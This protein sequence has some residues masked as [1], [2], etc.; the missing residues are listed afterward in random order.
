[1]SHLRPTR[2]RKLAPQWYSHS[3]NSRPSSRPQHEWLRSCKIQ[4]VGSVPAKPTTRREN[5]L[6]KIRDFASPPL[7]FRFCVTGPVSKGPAEDPR[8]C[9]TAR[10]SYD[11]RPTT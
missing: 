6:S 3:G 4:E 8:F 9:V 2:G 10:F 1:M 5:N 7:F 11:L